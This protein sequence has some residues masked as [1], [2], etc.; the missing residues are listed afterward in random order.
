[1][2][3]HDQATAAK[4]QSI[5]TALLDL[6][7]ERGLHDT[8]V[9]VI[10]KRAG[11]SQGLLY[12]YFGNKQALV[13]ALYRECK[14]A[15]LSASMGTVDRAAPLKC[16]FTGFVSKSVRFFVTH[17]QEMSFLAQF[18]ALPEYGADWQQEFAEPIQ[19]LFD[20]FEDAAAADLLKPLPFGLLGEMTGGVI[21]AAAKGFVIRDESPD[22]ADLCLIAQAC[23]DMIR[24]GD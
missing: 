3:D 8:P 24:K 15:M 18:E 11:I 5:M 19:P 9:S 4:R 20:L 13:H 16:R 21:L 1:M 17:P 23:W 2:P 22:E 6:S 14:M 7:S 10:A 12:H